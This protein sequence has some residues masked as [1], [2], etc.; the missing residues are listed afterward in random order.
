MNHSNNVFDFYRNNPEQVRQA[1]EMKKRF[2]MM[3]NPGED[4][5]EPVSNL[6]YP[7][8]F[9]LDTVIL[10]K[11][12]PDNNVVAIIATSIYWRNYLK[13]VLSEGSNGVVVVVENP[14]NP[15]FTYQIEYVDTYTSYQFG[16][17]CFLHF[18]FVPLIAGPTLHT[19]GE[20]I[21]TMS[22]LIDSEF[23]PFFVICKLYHRNTFHTPV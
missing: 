10:P 22:N 17:V 8:I 5:G 18:Y 20:V 21:S 23:Q 2:A 15:S 16:V 1:G 9:R 14:C 13:R 19:L 4:P 7:I 6:I 11:D 12:S 3:V